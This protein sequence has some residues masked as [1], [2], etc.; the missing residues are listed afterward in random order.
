MVPG[1]G[2]AMDL[3]TGARRVIVAMQHAA[4]GESKIVRQLTLPPTSMRAVSLVVTDMAVLEPT[5]G[6]LLLREC[7]PGVSVPE[8]LAATEAR[9]VVPDTVPEMPI[10]AVRA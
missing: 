3:V 7:A 6:G 8:V 10:G 5:P 4:K 1:M 2:G 9:L